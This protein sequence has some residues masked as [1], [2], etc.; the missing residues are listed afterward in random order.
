MEQEGDGMTVYC[1]VVECKNN[2]NGKCRNEFQTGEKAI[3]LHMNW[4]GVLACT[5]FE[6]SEEA[7]E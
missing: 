3:K 5:D 4:M 6:E 7:E 1:D 2:E